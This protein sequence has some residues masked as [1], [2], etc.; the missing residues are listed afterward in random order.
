MRDPNYR[1]TLNGRGTSRAAGRAFGWLLV[2]STVAVPAGAAAISYDT[3]VRSAEGPHADAFPTDAPL[4]ISYSLDP[5]ATDSNSD[6]H[7]GLF[8]SAVLSLSVSVPEAGVDVTAGPA[9]TAQTFDNALDQAAGLLSDQVFLFGG[10]IAPAVPLDGETI[11][12][13]E[14]D[15]LTA[16]DIAEPTMLSDDHLPLFPLR[17]HEG[18]V[19]FQTDSGDTVVHF[20][21][22][23]S[24]GSTPTPSPTGTPPLTSTPLPTNTSPPTISPTPA[25]TATASATPGFGLSGNGCMIGRG[26]A[27]GFSDLWIL[28]LPPLLALARSSSR[29]KGRGVHARPK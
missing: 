13:L 22:T 26:G 19:H 8:R 10:A 1:S 28:L 7:E 15:F 3:A 21:D 24:D 11:L 17:F 23:G 29:M 18:F 6:P 2:A 16:F 12:S 9:G 27:G 4:A 25:G 14:V 20:S 5:T